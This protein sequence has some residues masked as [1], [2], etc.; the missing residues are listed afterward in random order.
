M[1]IQSQMVKEGNNSFAMDELEARKLKYPTILTDLLLMGILIQGK[2]DM[3]F[4][5]PQHPPLTEDA[6]RALDRAVNQ[7][8]KPDDDGEVTT[9]P[10]FG[11]WSELESP[12]Q[13][14]MVTLGFNDAKAK[15][16]SSLSSEYEHVLWS[17]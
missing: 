3:C 15:E 5:N 10:L 2:G 12:G 4:F 1:K 6:Q 7:K 8:L 13:K 11:I 14:I 9:H 17:L 16:L